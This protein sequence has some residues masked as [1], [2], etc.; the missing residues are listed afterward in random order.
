M[1][2]GDYGAGGFGLIFGGVLGIAVSGLGL[3]LDDFVCCLE[4]VEFGFG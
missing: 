4:L 3:L 1:G 2:F